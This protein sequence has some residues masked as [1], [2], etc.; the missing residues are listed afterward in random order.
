MHHVWGND[1]YEQN[2]SLGLDE[3]VIPKLML[4][5]CGIAYRR[6]ILVVLYIIIKQ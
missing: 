2:L 3:M 4:Y 5:Y 1:K 6:D